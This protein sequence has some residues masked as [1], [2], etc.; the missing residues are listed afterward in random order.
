M[1]R[2][3]ICNALQHNVLLVPDNFQENKPNCS[4]TIILTHSQMLEY[5]NEGSLPLTYIQCD[6]CPGNCKLSCKSSNPSPLTQHVLPFEQ[7]IPDSPSSPDVSIS[8]D[9]YYPT[10]PEDIFTDSIMEPIPDSPSS[11]DAST[12]SPTR[13]E[14]SPSSSPPV[15]SSFNAFLNVEF[16]PDGCIIIKVNPT[17]PSDQ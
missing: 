10:S 1:E 17:T 9:S 12:G 2:I 16:S 3:D 13:P 6:N 4:N 7:P 15:P 5:L 11:P 8:P 14:F